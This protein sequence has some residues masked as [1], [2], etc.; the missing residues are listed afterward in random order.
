MHL[1]KELVQDST[2]ELPLLSSAVL[3][4]LVNELQIDELSQKKCI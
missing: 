3:N 2:L 4:Q 1:A